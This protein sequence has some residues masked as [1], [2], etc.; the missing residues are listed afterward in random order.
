MVG[1]VQVFVLL[2]I[3]VSFVIIVSMPVILATPG[4]WDKSQRLIL[5]GFTLWGTVLS[6]IASLNSVIV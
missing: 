4:V 6:L 3:V 5:A 2:L 1:I